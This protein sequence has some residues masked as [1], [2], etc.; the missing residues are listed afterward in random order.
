[1]SW[2]GR[3][4][5]T[6]QKPDADPRIDLAREALNNG[7]DKPGRNASRRERASANPGA[8]DLDFCYGGDSGPCA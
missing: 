3:K 4:D 1:M 2:F 8:V 5:E 6:P 7:N